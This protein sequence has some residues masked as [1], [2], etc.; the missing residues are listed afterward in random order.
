MLSRIPLAH[1]PTPL[2]PLPGEG[3]EQPVYYIFDKQSA[4]NAS[5]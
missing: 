4:E 5:A 2:E 1:L 3:P